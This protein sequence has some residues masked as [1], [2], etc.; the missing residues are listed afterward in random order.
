M[1]GIHP[2]LLATRKRHTQKI[3]RFDGFPKSS[4]RHALIGITHYG[5]TLNKYGARSTV[6]AENSG[7][8]I[9]GTPMFKART[10]YSALVAWL[11]DA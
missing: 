11:L 4:Q 6:V 2:Y 9:E 5:A 1:D 8:E 7:C 3:F 10:V